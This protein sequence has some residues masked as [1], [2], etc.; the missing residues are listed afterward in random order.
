MVGVVTARGAAGE[1]PLK[2]WPRPSLRAVPGSPSTGQVGVW[3]GG[4]RSHWHRTEV[5][6]RRFQM[7]QAAG[8]RAASLCGKQAL[9]AW[10]EA[11]WL[12]H[13]AEEEA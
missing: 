13:V 6:G 7:L 12:Q 8:G 3:A 10:E 1:R 4:A 2:S 9:G 11:A 5:L